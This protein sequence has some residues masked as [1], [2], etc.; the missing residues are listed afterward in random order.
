MIVVFKWSPPVASIC[1]E[2]DEIIYPTYGQRTSTTVGTARAC[3]YVSELIGDT[4][5]SR[6][7][8]G[9]THFGELDRDDAPCTLHAELQPERACREPAETARQ[10]PERDERASKQN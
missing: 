2:A 6:A 7:E 9:R 10:D 5:E 3:T 4:R 8:T 1:A